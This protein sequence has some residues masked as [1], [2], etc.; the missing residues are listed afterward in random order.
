MVTDIMPERDLR[1][2]SRAMGSMGRGVSQITGAMDFA[3][4]M[5]R[6]SGRP[7]IW[8]ALGVDGALNQHGRI[9]VESQSVKI[10][11][12]R[13]LNEVEGLRLYAQASTVNFQSQF[14]LEDY[15]L[16]DTIPV[17]KEAL[18]GN[19]VQVK[20]KKLADPERRAKMKELQ[21]QRGGLWGAG[22][23]MRDITVAWIPLDIPNGLELQ[24]KYEGYSL[25]EIADREN[26]HTLDVLLDL[27]LA[28][29][30][31]V[32]F[33]TKTLQAPVENMREVANST[34]A[35]PGLSDGGAH[36]KFITTGRYPTELLGYWVREHKIMS[37]EQ[38]HWRLSTYPAMAAGL[39]NRGWLAEGLPA[40]IVIYDPDT[41]D[42]LPGE[43][44]W[45]YPANEWRLVQKAT[46]YH[47]I[48][49]NGVETFRDGVCTNETPGKLLRHGVA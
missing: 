41:V 14:T 45:D 30:L 11:K 12:L 38:A 34:M 13:R 4:I 37:L 47:H 10:A 3:E 2:F 44:L 18:A 28:G 27:S 5:A 9:G 46:G 26:K 15:N 25:G 22:Y 31:Q 6:E 39:K 20:M 7:V 49:V 8:N 23:V 29:N 19:D 42:S 43:R 40:D 48:I 36:T 24:R 32:G 16:A 1:A 17:W 35:L 21:D 33:A